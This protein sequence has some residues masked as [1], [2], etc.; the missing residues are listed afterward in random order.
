[1]GKQ[2]TSA[3][4]LRRARGSHKP[5]ASPRI[6]LPS[7]AMPMA[8]ARLFVEQRCQCDGVL[9]LHHWRGTWW[10]WRRSYWCEMEND[11]ARSLLYTFTENACYRDA[12]G[13][14][15]PWA[16][17][18]KKIGDLLE[19]L[20]A[21]T[22][23]AADI[24][25]PTWL[26]GRSTGTIVAV[27]NGLLEVETRHL[28]PHSPQFFN[29]T[30][31]P[32]DYDKDAPEPKRWYNFLDALWPDEPT[33]IDVLG[34]WF[35][36]VISGRLDLHKIF[37]MVGPTRGGKG[38]IARILTALVR[39]KNVAG[40]TLSSFGTEFGL[41]PL[42]GKSLAIISDARSGSGKNS[43][44]TVERM[45]S[46][47]GE[48][49]LTV[50]RKYKGHWNGKLAARLHLV[51]NELPRLGDASSAIV[52]RLLL[53]LTT[54]SWLGKEDYEL[55]KKL[56][57][58]L[59]GILNWSLDGL[60]RLTVDNENHFTRF[61]AA[62]DAITQMRD[63][64]SP[65]G[66]FVREWCIL[67]SN[68]EIPVDDLYAHYK[69]FC[70]E[71][72]YPKLSKAR[73]GSD[74]R[75]A[76]PSIKKTRPRDGTKRHYVYAGIRLRIQKDEE[77]EAEQELPLGGL[78]NRPGPRTTRTKTTVGSPS[79]PSGPSK[80][81]NVVPTTDGKNPARDRESPT[82]GGKSDDLPYDGPVVDVPDQGPDDL[83][84]HGTPLAAQDQGT[85]ASVPFMLT[86]E[87]KRRLRFCGYSDEQIAGMT[88][89][90][91]HDILGQLA[92]QPTDGSAAGG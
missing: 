5:K 14:T 60:Q 6:V 77:A 13:D 62:D 76:C 4:R 75:A 27:A 92:P 8:V 54:R 85:I 64:A 33:A 46:I 42:I 40:P 51:S 74:L 15:V 17:T 90:E 20:A 65:V 36:Y 21:I 83:D 19:A 3:T 34:E 57:P 80:K 37:V 22:I 50:N 82:H 55:E 28:L 30:A 41:E 35:G 72:E 86:K 11:A 49:T 84:E 67:D 47:S 81:P 29:Q 52:G 58:E 79:G 12:D 43:P 26:D 48:D 7:P 70:P 10:E 38:V 68:A 63:L 78:Y 23:L 91:A 9:T 66:A 71:C 44:A 61:A 24:D 32:F 16:P 73:F 56:L 53:L 1:M 69:D 18:R 31:V 39:K 45:L 25:Q 59:P 88:P 2:G 89:Q 87:M